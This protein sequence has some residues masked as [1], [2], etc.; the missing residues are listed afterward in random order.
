LDSST[1]N[2]VIN[3]KISLGKHK[4]IYFM[5]YLK[6][7]FNKNESNGFKDEFE[8]YLLE[9]EEIKEIGEKIRKNERKK[10]S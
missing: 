9:N 10:I 2:L 3:N 7:Y 6:S 4:L 8:A 1:V 5:S